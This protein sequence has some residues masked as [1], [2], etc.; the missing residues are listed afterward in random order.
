MSDTHSLTCLRI[1]V[2]G[3]LTLLSRWLDRHFVPWKASDGLSNSFEP[4]C[5]SCVFTPSRRKKALSVQMP[6]QLGYWL[7]SCHSNQGSWQLMFHLQINY[8]VLLIEEKCTCIFFFFF[9][10]SLFPSWI[11]FWCICVTVTPFPWAVM[12]HTY[13]TDYL[14]NV[15]VIILLSI[16]FI[17][18]KTRL[19]VLD[20]YPDILG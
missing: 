4:R 16:F 13:R 8:G 2:F 7:D 5:G 11:S 6:E 10:F 19:H 14:L 1:G 17:L 12:W 20:I 15:L 18:E 3:D 9:S